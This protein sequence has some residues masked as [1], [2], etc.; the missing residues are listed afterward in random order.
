VSRTAHQEWFSEKLNGMLA[1]VETRL[2]K[3]FGATSSRLEQWQATDYNRGGKFDYHLDSGYWQNRYAG[4]RILTFLLHLRTP[5]KGGGTHFR[6]LDT[7][8]EGKIGRLVVWENLFSNGECNYKMIH[9]SGPLRK[10]KKTTLV[11]WLR[12]RRYRNGKLLGRTARRRL[13]SDSPAEVMPHR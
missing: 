8:V 3:L 4:E 7:Y 5:V 12:Q 1:V 6:A 9:S 13:P 2:Q 11:T 10:G